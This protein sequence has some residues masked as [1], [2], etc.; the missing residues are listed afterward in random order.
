MPG[1]TRFLRRMCPC[2]SR[3]R[4]LLDRCFLI[5]EIPCTLD[6]TQAALVTRIGESLASETAALVRRDNRMSP[7]GQNAGQ[8]SF[9]FNLLLF[10][11]INVLISS[12]IESSFSHC[13]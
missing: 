12:A 2:R 1:R 11:A 7:S 9:T 5:V 13:S 4:E 10:S 6:T 8:L 3:E